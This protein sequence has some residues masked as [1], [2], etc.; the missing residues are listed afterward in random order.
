MDDPTSTTFGNTQAPTHENI[1]RRAQELWEQYGRPSGRDEDIW[2]EAERQLRAPTSPSPSAATTPAER[3][4]DGTIAPAMK[5]AT[6]PSA[7]A[8]TTIS[9]TPKPPRAGGKKRPG[10]G[11]K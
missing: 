5:S 11:A 1:S 6:A 3:L 9:S 7:S 8:P 4:D 2:L 10:G